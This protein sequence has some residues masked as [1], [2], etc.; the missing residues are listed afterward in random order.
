MTPI[1]YCTRIVTAE[2]RKVAFDFDPGECLF[3]P[4]GRLQTA[5]FIGLRNVNPVPWIVISRIE[6]S[7]VCVDPQR[8]NAWLQKFFHDFKNVVV[9]NEGYMMVDPI[10]AAKKQHPPLFKP[11]PLRELFDRDVNGTGWQFVA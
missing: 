11:Y 3:K 5:R 6:Y 8:G 7:I 4:D 10:D 2:R 9:L 1:H